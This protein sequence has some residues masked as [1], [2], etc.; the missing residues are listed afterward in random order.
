M[1]IDVPE[2][3]GEPQIVV[4]DDGVVGYVNGD[5]SSTLPL[6]HADGG[7]QVLT[8]IETSDAPFSYEYALTLPEGA[9]LILNDDG[10]VSVESGDGNLLAYVPAPWARDAA[11]ASV[12]TYYRV[13]GSSLVQVVQHQGAA[14]PVVADPFWI[15]VLRLV[16]Q[17]SKHA[18]KQIA[19]RNITE[20]L[21]KIALQ[22]GR[23][24]KGKEKGTSVFEASGIRV[25]VNDKTGTIITVTRSGGGGS[26]G[27]R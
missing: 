6:A 27:G 4:A 12:P 15:P 20:N 23:R 22:E 17:W 7:L 3:E 13:Q 5:G 10:S 8:V 2:G 25:V 11:G 16:A 18:L 21:V 9:A 24:T 26:S 1:T 14:Y 19:E